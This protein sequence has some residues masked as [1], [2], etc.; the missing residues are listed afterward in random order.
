[1]LRELWRRRLLVAVV[2][3]IA[4]L[5][6]ILVLYQISFPPKLTSRKYDVGVATTSILVDTPRSQVV[7]V[8][9]KGADTIGARASLLAS[10]MADGDVKDQIARTAGLNPNDLAGVTTSVTD[11]TSTQPKDPRAPVLTTQ[12]VTQ[13]DGFNLPI[14]EVQ[15]QARDATTAAKLAAASVTGLRSY[16]ASTA[17]VQRI[18]DAHR[19][20]ITGLG[21]PQAQTSTRGPSTILGLAAGIGVFALGCL[22]ILGGVGFARRWRAASAGEHFAGI[23]AGD[24]LPRPASGMLSADLAS[25]LAA[26]RRRSPRSRDDEEHGA[27]DGSNGRHSGKRSFLRPQRSLSAAQPADNRAADNG[28][29]HAQTA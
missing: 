23:H 16:L 19:V 29:Q 3:V 11:G 17:A 13:N 26:A 10:L 7:D 12:V 4:A 25:E 2:A 8:D 18:P 14:I 22:C 6:G 15:A 20:H 28:E 5:A 9:P 24:R 21:V 1:M 27:P